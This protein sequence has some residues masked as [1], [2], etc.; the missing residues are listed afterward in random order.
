MTQRAKYLGRRSL[1]PKVIVHTHT[2]THTHTPS[3]LTGR[4]KWL[5]KVSR[6][7]PGTFLCHVWWS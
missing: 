4:L 2:H 5:V 7:H 3:I 1:R 6:T